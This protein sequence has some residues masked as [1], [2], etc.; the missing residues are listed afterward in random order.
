[1]HN[2]SNIT[3]DVEVIHIPLLHVFYR[4]FYFFIYMAV[5]IQ[6]FSPSLYKEVK[7]TYL[8]MTGEQ[9][10]KSLYCCF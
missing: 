2:D 5:E 7:N 10:L 8:A 3:W 1:M 9:K 4:S 6:Y